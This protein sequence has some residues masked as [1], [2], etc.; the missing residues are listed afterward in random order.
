MT[1]MGTLVMIPDKIIEGIIEAAA[2]IAHH[3]PF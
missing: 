1:A 3:A 2:G